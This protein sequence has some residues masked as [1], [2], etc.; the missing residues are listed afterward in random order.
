[1]RAQPHRGGRPDAQRTDQV[2]LV[3]LVTK[4]PVIAANGT[5]QHHAPCRLREDSSANLGGGEL[6]IGH[7]TYQRAHAGI[8][9]PQRNVGQ[10]GRQ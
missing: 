8:G 1:M 3:Q 6:V 9:A 2:L 10:L 4:R 5:A 7:K